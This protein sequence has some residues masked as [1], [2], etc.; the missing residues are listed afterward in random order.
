MIRPNNSI[1]FR[2]IVKSKKVFNVKIPGCSKT[3]ATGL[4]GATGSG[5]TGPLVASWPATLADL[6]FRKVKTSTTIMTRAWVGSITKGNPWPKKYGTIRGHFRHLE[7]RFFKEFLI[8]SF[9]HFHQFLVLPPFYF[10]KLSNI[11]WHSV[12]EIA[13]N[14]WLTQITYQ[15]SW[16][17][18]YLSKTPAWH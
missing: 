5:T 18:K 4:T 2:S 14:V 12:S 3:V 13:I 10:I 9:E 16:K 15:C 11:F 1:K 6:Q 7:K 17:K 8:T